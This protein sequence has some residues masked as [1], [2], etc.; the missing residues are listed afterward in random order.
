MFNS[1]LKDYVKV[2]EGFYNEDFCKE[3]VKNFGDVTW[4]PHEFY[5]PLTKTIYSHEHELSVSYEAVPFKKELDDKLWYAINGYV[6]KD[7]GF[8]KQWFSS[9]AG[10]SHC[11][12]NRYD[13]STQM[14]L[15]C[16]HI[17]SL[18][19]GDRK[20]IPILTV[21]GAL[22]EDYAGGEF[23]LCG[24]EIKLKQG[25]VIVFPSNFLYPHE[26]KPVTSGVR[27]SFVS[28]VW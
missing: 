28:W 23:V 16:D 14:T 25:D 11:R 26:V 10:Y 27:Y 2:Y 17:H 5:N 22:N 12:F 18:F 3:L 9:W 19:D 1:Q 6:T 13:V 4:Q 8:M 24:E 20:G 21:L 7:M 15:H